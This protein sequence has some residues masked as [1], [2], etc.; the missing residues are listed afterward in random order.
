MLLPKK[1]SLVGMV[2]LFHSC[3]VTSAQFNQYLIAFLMLAQLGS[4]LFNSFSKHGSSAGA[5]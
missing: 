4:D 5:V 1:P 2:L 3:Q